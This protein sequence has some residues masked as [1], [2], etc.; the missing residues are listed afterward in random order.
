MVYLKP[1]SSIFEY[2]VRWCCSEG[3]VDEYSRIS[4]K[5]D[6]IMATIQAQG[7]ASVD[8]ECM[9]YRT[10]CNTYSLKSF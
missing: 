8:T 2:F 10:G 5:K 7:V 6:W 3:T 1:C 4:N 9:E